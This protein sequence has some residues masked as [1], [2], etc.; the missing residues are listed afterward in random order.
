MIANIILG[1]IFFNVGV[2]GVIYNVTN[3]L[4]KLHLLWLVPLGWI[5]LAILTGSLRNTVM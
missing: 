1:L 3:S 2:I 5:G 4:S